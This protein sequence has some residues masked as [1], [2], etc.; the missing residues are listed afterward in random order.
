MQCQILLKFDRLVHHVS[1][2][3]AEWL[4]TLLVIFKMAL[5]DDAQLWK[6][7]HHTLRSQLR[8]EATR[9][10]PETCVGS[11]DDDVAVNHIYY[12]AGN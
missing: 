11:A 3:I 6:W 5:A 2:K 4:N 8:N 1:R 12:I 9:L 7:L 10:K